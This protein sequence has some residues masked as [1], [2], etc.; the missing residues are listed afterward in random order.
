MG[1]LSELAEGQRGE[2][3]FDLHRRPNLYFSPVD[4]KLHLLGA[5]EGRWQIDENREILY[6]N[7]GGDYL[8][9]WTLVENGA[10]TRQLY[11]VKG[12][13]IYE[14]GTGVKW[15]RT[16]QSPAMFTMSPPT[17][18]PELQQLNQELQKYSKDILPW[19]FEAM[20]SQF[21]TS[22]VQVKDARVKDLRLTSS[23]FRF[24][25]E[26]GASVQTQGLGWSINQPL[27]EGDALVTYDGDLK[28]ESISLPE[29]SLRVQ[30]S[31]SQEF[32][33][34]VPASLLLE[35]N[36]AGLSDAKDVLLVVQARQGDTIVE[37]S[38]QRL[39]I[40]FGTPTR[41][42]MTWIPPT[43]GMWDIHAR[44]AI[45]GEM[46]VAESAPISI[47]VEEISASPQRILL[48]SL[49]GSEQLLSLILTLLA[50]FSTA[51][52]LAWFALR[53]KI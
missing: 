53:R 40:F 4:R 17:S 27:S 49:G 9:S 5:E 26:N 3:S 10:P 36:N 22:M 7:L 31:P 41:V 39:D 52:L 20:L 16:E 19:D 21:G 1:D 50:Y 29:L 25:L 30:V 14:D 33:V 42:G 51:T 46:V 48:L 44:M 6:K 37:I 45:A 15:V 24:V 23:G 38:R 11:F 2:L 12:F 47:G 43:Y 35:A 34:G 18:S 32:T 28:I 8:N 13:L